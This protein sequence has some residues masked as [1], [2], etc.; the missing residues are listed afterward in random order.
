VS[1]VHLVI[2][3]ALLAVG[4]ACVLGRN[5]IVARHRARSNGRVVQSPT[6]YLG[7]GVI[8]VLAGLVQVVLAVT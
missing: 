7:M 4:G 1:V 3:I 2:G 5:R 8:A 6:L